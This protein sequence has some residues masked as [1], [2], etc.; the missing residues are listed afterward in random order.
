[1]QRCTKVGILIHHAN[2]DPFK[3]QVQ[4]LIAVQP[5]INVSTKWARFRPESDVREK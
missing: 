1:M 5:F 2:S 3:K 4:E